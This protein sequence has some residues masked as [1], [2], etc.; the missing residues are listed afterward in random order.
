MLIE[1]YSFESLAEYW[2]NECNIDK[3][4]ECCEDAFRLK[5]NTEAMYVFAAYAFYQKNWVERTNEVIA[6]GLRLYPNSQNIKFHKGLQA[7]NA[8]NWK[9][10]W[11][12]WQYRCNR[13][14]ISANMQEKLPQI[15]EWDGR[16]SPESI[17]VFGEHGLGDQIICSRFLKYL[18]IDKIYFAPRDTLVPL[19]VGNKEKF[20]L[21][22]V[23]HPNESVPKVDCWCGLE[24]IPALLNIRNSSREKQYFYG[25]PLGHISGRIGICWNS[26]PKPEP[27]RRIPWEYFSRIIDDKH[28]FVSLQFGEDCPDKRVD[29]SRIKTVENLQDTSHL[30]NSSMAFCCSHCY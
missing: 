29:T 18:P 4:V 8:G 12:Y 14:I 21:F 15:P 16:S 5:H 1:G 17:M 19:F 6:E 28:E 26:S 25:K 2:Q 10:G 23:I 7:L 13:R 20:N 27:Y 9:D 3:M 30:L 24:S 11:E 22:K